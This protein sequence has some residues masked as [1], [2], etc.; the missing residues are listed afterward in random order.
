M[1]TRSAAYFFLLFSLCS[2]SFLGVGL[3]LLFLRGLRFRLGNGLPLL[4][5]GLL[6]DG[7]LLPLRCC[8]LLGGRFLASFL[9][10]R[11]GPNRLFLCN[12]LH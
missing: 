12:T 2:S 4:L 10:S 6:C 5:G 8:L 11:S 7:L 3:L 9:R 1:Q